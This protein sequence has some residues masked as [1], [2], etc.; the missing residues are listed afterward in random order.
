MLLILM[1]ENESYKKVHWE[2]TGCFVRY[3][4]NSVIFYYLLR[5]HAVLR[6]NGWWNKRFSK[7]VQ[8]K[9]FFY[10]RYTFNLAPYI[11]YVVYVSF[12]HTSGRAYVHY[13]RNICE[14]RFM[15]ISIFP[16]WELLTVSSFNMGNWYLSFPK[17][18]ESIVPHPVYT[19]NFP[20]LYFLFNFFSFD[21]NDFFVIKKKIFTLFVLVPV[22]IGNFVF[23]SFF[24]FRSINRLKMFFVSW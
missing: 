7:H 14:N 21:Y 13:E 10:C 19:F 20:F 11:P 18:V 12:I 2:Y 22:F 8:E 16:S 4:T 24:S 15:S 23:F 6:A 3:K 17:T 1:Y 5:V 9:E